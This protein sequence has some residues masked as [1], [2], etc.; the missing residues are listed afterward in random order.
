MDKEIWKAVKSNPLYEVSNKGRAR[1]WNKYGGVRS[2][3]PKILVP[4][5]KNNNY[6]FIC[7]RENGKLIDKS[8]HRLVAEVFIPNPDNKSQI[9]HIDRNRG[10]NRADNL[11][12]VTPTENIRHSIQK[13][14]TL[15]KDGVIKKF[16]YIQDAADFLGLSGSSCLSKLRRG[17]RK[18]IKGWSLLK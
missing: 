2:N 17:K 13:P 1:S 12:W 7:L 16:D 11:E 4:R 6:K 10:N 18:T 15:I 3:E 14:I 9:N 5:E 8:I